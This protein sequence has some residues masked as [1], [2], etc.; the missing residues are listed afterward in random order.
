MFNSISTCLQKK[1]G[2]FNI[3]W[4]TMYHLQVVF[5]ITAQRGLRPVISRGVPN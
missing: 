2:M 3:A 4:S 5:L 1:S